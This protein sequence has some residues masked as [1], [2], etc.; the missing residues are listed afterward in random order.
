ME[1]GK[2][3]GAVHV[4]YFS[5]TMGRRCSHGNDMEENLRGEGTV[6][7]KW[8]GFIMGGGGVENNSINSANNQIA[9]SV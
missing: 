2:V 5:S 9:K 8:S 1:R 6:K 4:L 7:N 3:A